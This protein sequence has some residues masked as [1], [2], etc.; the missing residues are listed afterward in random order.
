M[1]ELA[2]LT[3]SYSRALVKYQRAVKPHVL[4]RS[5]IKRRD[6]ERALTEVKKTRKKSG[7]KKHVQKNR[8][9]YKRKAQQQI[10]ERTVEEQTYLDSVVNTKIQRKVTATNKEYKKWL[11]NLEYKVKKWK[12]LR[13]TNTRCQR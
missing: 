12:A 1:N 2:P 4:E 11:R 5:A 9:I 10:L 6:E 13:V 8:V 7:S 3:L